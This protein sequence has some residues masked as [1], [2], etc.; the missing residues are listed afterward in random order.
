MGFPFALQKRGKLR[1]NDVSHAVMACWILASQSIEEGEAD[2]LA[3]LLLEELGSV[4]GQLR[5]GF[6][7]KC[8]WQLYSEAWKTQY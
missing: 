8:I 6:G 7:Q 2:G 3:P 4:L 1:S 5:L